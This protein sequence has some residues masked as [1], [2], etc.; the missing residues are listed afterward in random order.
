MSPAIFSNLI[1]RI[2]SNLYADLTGAIPLLGVDLESKDLNVK[3][4]VDITW[5]EE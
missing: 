2:V 5:N 1:I 3:T 4:L